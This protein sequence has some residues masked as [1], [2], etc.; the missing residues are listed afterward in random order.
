MTYLQ[1][2]LWAKHIPLLRGTSFVFVLICLNLVFLDVTNREAHLE[3]Y[4]FPEITLFCK[5]V[6]FMKSVFSIRE[7]YL[8]RDRDIEPS[9]F[10]SY[11]GPICV[12]WTQEPIFGISHFPQMEKGCHVYTKLGSNPYHARAYI[13]IGGTSNPR[14]PMG[15]LYILPLRT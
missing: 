10:W 6:K 9:G 2:A 14:D 13:Y 15:S 11:F 3:K 8:T 12:F 7:V 1:G 5:S 4:V